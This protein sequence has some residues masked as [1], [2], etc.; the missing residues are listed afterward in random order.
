MGNVRYLLSKY[1]KTLYLKT[2]PTFKTKLTRDLK[3]MDHNLLNAVLL[4]ANWE[5]YFTEQDPNN[6]VN[7]LSSVITE[8]MDVVAP[9]KAIRQYKDGIRLQPDT[10]AVMSKR[11]AARKTGNKQYKTL[12]N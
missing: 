5:R 6:L 4:D 2:E 9:I 1:L 3:N 12:R 7:W 11:D 10:R 8:A